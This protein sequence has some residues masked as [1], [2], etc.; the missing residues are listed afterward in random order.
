[1]DGTVRR[2]RV[3]AYVV[4]TMLLLLCVVALPL[5]YV[6]NHP[7][8]AQYGFTI[9]GLVYIVYLLTVADLARKRHLTAGRIGALVSAGF[10]PGLAFVQER[11]LTAAMALERT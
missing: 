9:H 11:R 5:Q 6:W 2:Y 8:F 3:M 1:M 10:V 7:A 4:G